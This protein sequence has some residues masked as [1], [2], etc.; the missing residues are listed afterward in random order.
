M[1]HIQN[2]SHNLR[3]YRKIRGLTQAQLAALVY[4]AAQNVS[5]WELGV[6]QT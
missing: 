2:L 3:K 5:K 6:S 1:Y 4:V